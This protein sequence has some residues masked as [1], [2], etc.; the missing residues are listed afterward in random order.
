MLIF[1]SVNGRNC[2]EKAGPSKR[3]R[4]ELWNFNGDSSHDDMGDKNENHNESEIDNENID[5]TSREY[6]FYV[7]MPSISLSLSSLTYLQS[8]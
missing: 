6:F 1:T 3:G 7:G 8:K 2:R 4:S 5:Q